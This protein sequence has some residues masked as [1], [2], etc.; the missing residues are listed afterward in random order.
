MTQMTLDDWTGTRARASDPDTS[1]SAG[2]HVARTTLKP[3]NV[4]VLGVLKRTDG[5]TQRDMETHPR[6]YAKYSPSRIR[7]AV[8]EL[9]QAGLVEDTGKR[10]RLE[11]GRKAIVW[12]AKV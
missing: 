12:R 7:S 2:N 6:L 11:S 9:R 1:K 10:V 5:R 8:S 3:S 4:D